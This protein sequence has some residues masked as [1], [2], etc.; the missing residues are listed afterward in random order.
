MHIRILVLRQAYFR[1]HVMSILL[2]HN[3]GIANV[4]AVKITE[5]VNER[6]QRD[7]S[8]VDFEQ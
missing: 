4:R 5:Q 7:N 6:R 3:L 1:H 2:V 8:G